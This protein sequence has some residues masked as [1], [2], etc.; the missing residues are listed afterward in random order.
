MHSERI[1]LSEA[2]SYLINQT[3]DSNSKIISVGT[4]SLRCLEAIYHQFG[5]VRPF[6]GETDIFIYPGFK[7]NVVDSLITNFHLPKTTLLLLVSA[8]AGEDTIKTAYKHAI[9]EEYMFFSYGDA[10]LLNRKEDF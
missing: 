3:L 5:E 9:N 4:T 10:M 7:F 8:F 1:Y 2:T 6:E